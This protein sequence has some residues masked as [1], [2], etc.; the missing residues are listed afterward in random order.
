MPSGEEGSR[1]VVCQ[2]PSSQMA[3]APLGS[4]APT[5]MR[6]TRSANPPYEFCHFFHPPCHEILRENRNIPTNRQV[7][8]LLYCRRCS[9]LREGPREGH[10]S[11]K[12]VLINRKRPKEQRCD[13]EGTGNADTVSKSA[14]SDAGVKDSH[15]IGRSVRRRSLPAP[16]R[17]SATKVNP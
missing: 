7:R 10:A 4:S 8:S 2:G 16:R 17:T 6:V 3:L 11:L 9:L 15:C 1:P 13:G 14:G 12:F 5:L